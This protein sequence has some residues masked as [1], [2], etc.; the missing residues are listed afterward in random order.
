MRSELRDKDG[1]IKFLIKK[2]SKKI[3]TSLILTTM[4]RRV[5]FFLIVKKKNFIIAPRLRIL[6]LIKLEQE[7][8]CCLVFSMINFKNEDPELSLFLSS[9]VAANTVKEFGNDRVIKVKELVKILEHIY[10]K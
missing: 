9:L 8:Q 10:L 6:L 4:G 1:D 5:Q 2:L 7:M 3:N